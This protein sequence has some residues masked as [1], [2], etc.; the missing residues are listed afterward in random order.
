M[1]RQRSA[2]TIVRH[3]VLTVAAA[4]MTALLPPTPFGAEV[5]TDPPD[6]GNA[7]VHSL[8]TVDGSP[9]RLDP[10]A[11][12]RFGMA[13]I[14]GVTLADEGIDSNMIGLLGLDLRLGG[15]VDDPFAVALP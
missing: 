12:F 2:A 14:A 13:L 8:P 9:A 11:R 15:R 1:T 6:A 4:G 5:E 7:P 3:R 10:G